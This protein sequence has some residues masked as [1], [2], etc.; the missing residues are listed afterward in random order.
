M[1][2][3]DEFSFHTE[4]S[5]AAFMLADSIRAPFTMAPAVACLGRF[6]AVCS[7]VQVVRLL[8]V[9]VPISA[10][11]TTPFCVLPDQDEDDI[12]QVIGPSF[13]SWRTGA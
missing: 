9:A 8:Q 1:L 10:T 13:A 12:I 3:E 4:D 6:H 5:I 11:F 7:T 2:V